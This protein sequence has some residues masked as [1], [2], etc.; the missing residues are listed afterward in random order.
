MHSKAIIALT[1]LVGLLAPAGT[2]AQSVPVDCAPTA[3]ALDYW[4]PILASI[5]A[6]THSAD[7]LAPELSAC[8]GSE[9]S[10]LRDTIGYGLFTYWLRNE[11]LSKQSKLN[12]LTALSLNLEQSGIEHSLSRSFSALVVSELLR[13]DNLENFTD[14]SERLKLLHIAANALA[15][16]TDYRGL[17]EGIGWVHPVAHLADLLWRFAQHAELS[18]EQTRIILEGVRGKAG[19]TDT[20]FMFNEGDRLARPVAALIRREVLPASDFVNW[21]GSFATPASMESWFDVF[22]S[23][24]G[25]HELHNTK[26]FI[27]ALS[28]QLRTESVDADIRARL[29]E[30]VAILTAVV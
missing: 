14:D 5:S 7:Q 17:V 26:L 15:A 22:F 13:A 9:N 24:E 3:A 16:E 30:L 29:D 12:L 11:E 21:L 10:E 2:S 1:L 18:T 28:D 25:M 20:G 27:R 19:T 4:R 23:I 6:G 8:L